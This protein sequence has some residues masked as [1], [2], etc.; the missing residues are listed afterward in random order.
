MDLRTIFAMPEPNVADATRRTFIKLSGGAGAGLVLG[1]APLRFD[2]ETGVARA[3]DVTLEPNPFVRVAP[4]NTVTVIIKHLDKGQGA[5][6]GLSTLVAEEIDASHDQIRTEFA[7][8]DKDKYKNIAFGIQGVGG[9]T[10]LANS[11]E[12]Y[13]RAGATAR[14]TLV[15]AAAKAWDVD[16]ATITV[17]GG[18]VSSASGKSATL[19]ELAEKAAAEAVPKDVPLKIQRISFLSASRLLALIAQSRSRVR[20]NTRSISSSTTC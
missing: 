7:P 3:T 17:K 16:A 1:L 4:D 9:S 2:V 15:A 6:T 12:Q 13:R 10:G 11:Y 14:A 19:G 18:V 5:A 20:R 8:A